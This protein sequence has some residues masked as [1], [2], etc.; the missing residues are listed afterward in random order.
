MR[1]FVQSFLGAGSLSLRR[2]VML[3][4]AAGVIVP[5][6]LIGPFLARE[7]LRNDEQARIHALMT[8]YG[9]VLGAA[10]V[11]PLWLADPQSAGGLIQSVMANP[12]VVA[13]DVEDASLGTFLAESKPL[14]TSDELVRQVFPISKD[15][16]TIGTLTV[17]MTTRHVRGH[18]LLQSAKV[19]FALAFQLMLTLAILFVVFNRRLFRPVQALVDALR[20]MA[21]GDLRSRVQGFGHGDE[22]CALANG[23]D[24]MRGQLA[25]TLEDVRALNA[26]LEQRVIDRTQDLQSALADLERAQGEIERNERMAA[27]GAMVA[28]IS[29]ELNTPIGNAL[30]VSST[31]VDR[32]QRFQQVA[33]TRLT[34]TQLQ[35]FM[36]T[37]SEA[38]ALV[39]RNLEKAAQLIASFK[40]V[41]VDRTAAHR[42]EFDL[43][44][45]VQE[46]L[47]TLTAVLKRKG[48]VIECEAAPGICVDGYPGQLGQVLT[49]IVQNADLHGLDGREGGRILVSAKLLDAERVSI[50]VED[51]G[52]GI[53]QEHQGRVFDPFFTTRMGQGG[54][55]LGLNIVHNLVCNL[56]GGDI[57]VESEV[58][59]GT[60]FIIELPRVAPVTE[61]DGADA[62]T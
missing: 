22:L 21:G 61:K 45:V 37:S 5:A 41:A 6:L 59:R 25:R 51:N 44:T 35:A 48:Y 11:Q 16:S 39:Q 23:M 38:S 57:R 55:G 49:N 31:L 52:R 19:A 20:R 34:R 7:S 30:T 56:M 1:R 29:H 40:Q 3:A 28:G 15:G 4:T 12:D 10:L 62:S 17:T 46:V 2:V 53:P 42:R 60:C 32:V 14:Q 33:D 54:S 58:G 8:Q 9:S 26:E 24:D 13:I 18:L 43:E 47:L 27:L 36:D 50:R